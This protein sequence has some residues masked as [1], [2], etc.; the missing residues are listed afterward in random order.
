MAT[1]VS[2]SLTLCADDYGLTPGISRSIR[3][4]AAAGRISAA[5]CMTVLPGWPHQAAR[6]SAVDAPLEIG[7]HLVLTELPPLGPMPALAPRGRLPALG[8]LLARAA[9]GLLARPPVA[10]EIAAEVA[11]QLDAFEAAMGRPPAFVDGHQHV[12]ALHGVREAV[13]GLFGTRLDPARTWLRLCT[14]PVPEALRRGTAPHATLVIDRLSRPLRRLAEAR[15][16]RGPD[17]F[18]GV[19]RFRPGRVAQEFERWMTGPGRRVVVMCHPG[20]AEGPHPVPDPI[21]ARRVAEHA[22]LS[23]PRFAAALARH[24]LRLGPLP[25]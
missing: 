21:L 6:L 24:G 1:A 17:D 10:G 19:T 25:A 15:G 9:A 23:G 18:R 4:L 11:R 5:S 2:H 7:L 16:L 14:T 20:H 13:L 3:E 12:H 22:Y 8:P